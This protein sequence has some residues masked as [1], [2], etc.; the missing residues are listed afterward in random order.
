MRTGRAGGG[1]L[2]RHGSPRITP[3]PLL[4]TPPTRRPV[5]TTR[6]IHTNTSTSGGCH[7]AP[8]LP[9]LLR[10]VITTAPT[11]L[12]LLLLGTQTAGKHRIHIL[13]RTRNTRNSGT[14]AVAEEA[15]AEN[16]S[17]RRERRTAVHIIHVVVLV[18][19]DI[20]NRCITPQRRLL[21]RGMMKL[22]CVHPVVCI[23]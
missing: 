23:A 1:G 19:A 17:G 22:A 3:R 4:D 12:V 9:P 13:R 15:K 7:Q 18:V 5:H 10:R 21:R 16:A 6:N 20:R 11:L 2:C 8:L 14:A